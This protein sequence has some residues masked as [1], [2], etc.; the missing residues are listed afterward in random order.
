M[1]RA[2]CNPPELSPEKGLPRYDEIRMSHTGRWEFYDV[3]DD[4][5]KLID[6]CQAT[7]DKGN[8][9]PVYIFDRKENRVVWKGWEGDQ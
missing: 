6:Q 9:T 1:K 2:H 4:L 5:Q 3:A 8:L 7:I